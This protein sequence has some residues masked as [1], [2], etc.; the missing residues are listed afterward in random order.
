MKKKRVSQRK[1]TAGK[2][3]RPS[4]S[5][6]G[7]RNHKA[8]RK[9]KTIGSQIER[10]QG[11]DPTT[12]Q[13]SPYRLNSNRSRYALNIALVFILGATSVY[14][15][16][17]IL[18]TLR[19]FY[20][21][22]FVIPLYGYLFGV[23]IL[24][25]WHGVRAVEID[26]SGLKIVRTAHQP[27]MHIAFNDITGIRATSSIDGKTVDILLHGAT[28]KKFLWIYSYSGPRVHIHGAPFVTKDFVEFTERVTKLIPGASLL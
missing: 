12:T 26:S 11:N 27:V 8:S 20:T 21:L 15:Y 18:V 17:N 13:P 9:E 3:V 10:M 1:K 28:A 7:R 5:A 25:L 22:L 24:W 19:N 4:R 16:V 23:P 2:D 14:F 6:R